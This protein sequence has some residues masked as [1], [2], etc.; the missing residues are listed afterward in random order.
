MSMDCKKFNT[1]TVIKKRVADLSLQHID[2]CS[3]PTLVGELEGKL[4]QR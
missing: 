4:G 2:S 3:I 1:G